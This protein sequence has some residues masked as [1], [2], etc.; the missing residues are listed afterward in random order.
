MDVVPSYI[1]M[2]IMISF[3]TIMIPYP[4]TRQ[5]VS[6]F[7]YMITTF[8]TFV[9]TV[10][11]YIC[12]PL[13]SPQCR[14]YVSVNRVSIGSDGGLSP[15]RHQTIIWNNAWILLT[16]P[17]GT[18]FREILIEIHMFPFMKMHLKPSSAKWQTFCL[19][20]DVLITVTMNT[21]GSHNCVLWIRF[22]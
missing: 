5:F 19:G 2:T 21:P 15:T 16:E 10:H 8:H 13:I 3:I 14:I 12:I 6:I 17:L 18:N 20:L 7:F 1:F 22:A 11:L 4:H 9:F